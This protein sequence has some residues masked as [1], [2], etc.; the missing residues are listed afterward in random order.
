MK[1]R[2]ADFNDI[3]NILE[4]VSS[5]RKILKE[6]GINQWQ[7]EYPAASD[8]ANDISNNSAY[9]VECDGEVVGMASIL[10]GNKKEYEEI[11]GSWGTDG[12]YA[13][14]NRVGVSKKH[15]GK[16][17][18]HRILDEA[19]KICL[20]NGVFS[21][22]VDTCP[23]NNV[24]RRLVNSRGYKCRGITQGYGG[25]RKAYEKILDSEILAKV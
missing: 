11:D 3:E 5:A 1:F 19:E 12:A 14:I 7:G 6:K 22:R 24:M 13:V 4:I 23:A 15:T 16:G 2:P 21:V 8:F 18:S 25:I 10:F 20:K 9:V 17:I